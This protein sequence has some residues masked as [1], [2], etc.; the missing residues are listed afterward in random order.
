MLGTLYE[1]LNPAFRKE[2]NLKLNQIEDIRSKKY[3]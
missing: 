2:K 1:I 3:D